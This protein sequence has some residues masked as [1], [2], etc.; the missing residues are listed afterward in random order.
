MTSHELFEE[1]EVL[2]EKF[3][4]NHERYH[5]NNVKKCGVTARKTVNEI[6]KLASTYRMT[7]LAE[8][9]EL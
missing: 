1:M 4:R 5:N 9:R 6:R 8:S 7:N 3:K 2:W